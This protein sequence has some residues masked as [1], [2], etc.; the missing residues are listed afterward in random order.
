MFVLL[1]WSKLIYGLFGKSNMPHTLDFFLVQLSRRKSNVT[2]LRISKSRFAV[3][4]RK[5]VPDQFTGLRNRGTLKD[6]ND[7]KLTVY[8]FK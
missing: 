7:S 3:R 1:N 4:N 6:L 2:K 5:K 8:E